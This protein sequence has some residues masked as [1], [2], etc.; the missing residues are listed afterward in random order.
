MYEKKNLTY[1]LTSL[2]S[3]EKINIY[4]QNFSK[5]VELLEANDQMNFNA[6]QTLLLVIGEE[7]KKISADLKNEHQKIPWNL[8]AGLRNRIAHDYRNVDPNIT[9]DIVKNYLP[10]LKQELIK[11]LGKVDFEDTLLIKAINTPHYKHLQYLKNL[12]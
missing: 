1:I 11:M 10:D 5:A 4:T 7:S 2:E 8:I 12:S 6:C 9:F 3:I